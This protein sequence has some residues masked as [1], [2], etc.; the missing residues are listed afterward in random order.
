MTWTHARRPLD[1]TRLGS[2]LLPPLDLYL[3]RGDI[4]LTVY[5][6]GARTRTPPLRDCAHHGDRITVIRRNLALKRLAQT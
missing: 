5:N 2:G 1:S 3:A 4:S 6:R